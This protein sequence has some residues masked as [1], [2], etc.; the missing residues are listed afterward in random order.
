MR[1]SVYVAMHGPSMRTSAKVTA[2]FGSQLSVAVTAAG[3]GTASHS[4][5][6]SAGTLVSA[7]GVVSCTVTTCEAD[8]EFPQ[9]SVAVQ[10][11]VSV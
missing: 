6:A 2:G 3:D 11:R 5:V 1:R 9:R 4:T 7:G 10:V 8:V